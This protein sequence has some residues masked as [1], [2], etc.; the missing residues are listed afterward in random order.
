MYVEKKGETQDVWHLCGPGRV[1]D[2]MVRIRVNLMDR[3]D[4]IYSE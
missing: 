3:T 1:E 2:G 4:D